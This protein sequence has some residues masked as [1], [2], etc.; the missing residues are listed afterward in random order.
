MK[1][2]LSLLLTAALALSLLAGCGPK[3]ASNGSSSSTP[4]VSS[5]AG[6]DGSISSA[7]PGNSD[8]VDG[9]RF[10]VLSG[11]T[12]VGA[13]KLMTDMDAIS[14]A[15]V[16]TDNQEVTN[17]LINKDVDIAAIATNSAAMLYAQSDGAIQ[18]LAV[19]TLGVLYILEKGDTV[20]PTWRARLCTVPP[21]PKGPTRS[22]F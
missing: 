6:T 22:T 5:S 9:P 2:T 12:G 3:P 18:V 10:M 14:S 8:P 1:R 11:P 15:E 16:V 7:E 4:D 17:A 19:N 21:T 13:A 20:W